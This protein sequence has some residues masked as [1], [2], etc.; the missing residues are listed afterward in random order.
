M[1][2]EVA[3]KIDDVEYAVEK[4][5]LLAVAA[6]QDWS[7]SGLEVCKDQDLW[8]VLIRD[9]VLQVYEEVKQLVALG[10]LDPIEK[11]TGTEALNNG[12]G[13]IL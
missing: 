5:A 7:G 8:L 12:L 6:R 13:A 11:S 4:C 2:F 1:T 10:E 9:S 3:N